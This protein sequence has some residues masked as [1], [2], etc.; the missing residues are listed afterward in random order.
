MGKIALCLMLI[1]GLP[2]PGQTGQT[3]TVAQPNKTLVVYRSVKA[4]AT[5]A[6]EDCS[7]T[8]FF[9]DNPSALADKPTARAVE[10]FAKIFHDALFNFL[11][12]AGRISKGDGADLVI[13]S[14]VAQFDASESSLSPFQNTDT[15]TFHHWSGLYEVMAVDGKSGKP[16]FKFFVGGRTMKNEIRGAGAEAGADILG[17]LNGTL[18]APAGD[19]D[20]PGDK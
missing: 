5:I 12:D 14:R 15:W 10:K 8:K 1:A 7:T 16:M 4:T 17:V 6:V 9:Q 2:I 19:G 11:D 18:K 13:K 3:D 20:W